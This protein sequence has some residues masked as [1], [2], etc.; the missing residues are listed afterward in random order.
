MRCTDCEFSQETL[1]AQLNYVCCKLQMIEVPA[2][3]E[4]ESCSHRDND[5]MIR[6]GYKYLG[7]GTW[8]KGFRL[9]QEDTK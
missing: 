5:V 7:N 1:P 3:K 4:F 9:E 8:V 6:L 2:W